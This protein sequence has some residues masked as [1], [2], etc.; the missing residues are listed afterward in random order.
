MHNIH[1]TILIHMINTNVMYMNDLSTYVKY[2][3]AL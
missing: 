2:I 3:S 1:I